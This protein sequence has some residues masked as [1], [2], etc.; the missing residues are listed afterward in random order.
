MLLEKLNAVRKLL[1]GAVIKSIRND[2][3]EYDGLVLNFHN[4]AEII[5][6]GDGTWSISPEPERAPMVTPNSLRWVNYGPNCVVTRLGN[7][8]PGGN[9]DGKALK[10][11]IMGKLGL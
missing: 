7:S 11:N 2:A 1:K 9:I 3:L 5:L 10:G 6:S 4:G 8:H